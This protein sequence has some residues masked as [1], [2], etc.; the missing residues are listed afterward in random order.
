MQKEKLIEWKRENEHLLE[1]IRNWESKYHC[2]NECLDWREMGCCKHMG[3]AK[4][5]KFKKEIN[6]Q[7]VIILGGA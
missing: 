5:R 1:E 2:K 6:Q 7:M 4:E 3:N